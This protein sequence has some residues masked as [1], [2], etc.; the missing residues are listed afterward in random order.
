MESTKT[1]NQGQSQGH[2]QGT[3]QI[4]CKKKSIKRICLSTR[5]I[6]ADRTRSILYI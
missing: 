6:F 2:S 3:Y 1:Q 5:W 4:V